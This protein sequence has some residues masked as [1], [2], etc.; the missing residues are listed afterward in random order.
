MLISNHIVTNFF[1]ESAIINAINTVVSSNEQ[2]IRNA[3]A[4]QLTKILCKFS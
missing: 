1:H 2:F 4:L 3:L